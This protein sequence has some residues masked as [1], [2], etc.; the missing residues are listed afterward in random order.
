ME[1]TEVE[2]AEEFKQQGNEH[3]KKKEY[4]KAIESYTKA[5]SK[6][7]QD[8]FNPTKDLNPI[9]PSYYANRAAC[10]LGLNKYGRITNSLI[11]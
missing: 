6:I 3:F 11:I 1:Q 2:R 7:F 10:Y 8:F 9:D 5:I 4:I